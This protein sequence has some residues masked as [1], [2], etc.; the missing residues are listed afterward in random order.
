MS[1]GAEFGLALGFFSLLQAALIY[2]Y[3]GLF[4]CRWYKYTQDNRLVA[5]D[6]LVDAKLKK[7]RLSSIFS[8][9]FVGLSVFLIITGESIYKPSVHNISL[10]FFFLAATKTML[11]I[12]VLMGIVFGLVYCASSLL[13]YSR[14]KKQLASMV[15]EIEQKKVQRSVPRIILK[16]FGVAIALTIMA[17]LDVWLLVA[18][19][20]QS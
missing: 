13:A 3:K 2:W 19:S 18:L 20:V 15:R 4:I 5:A 11:S 14:G 8:F 9:F 6:L 10:P 16:T 17:V 7:I 12:F 1:F